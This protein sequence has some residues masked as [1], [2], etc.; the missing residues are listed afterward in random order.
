MLEKISM[1][2]LCP[3]PEPQFLYVEL[4]KDPDRG[5][6]AWHTYDKA[7]NASTPIYQPC[8]Q[9]R[10][11][12]LRLR[13]KKFKD[14]RNLKMDMTFQSGGT[15][16]TVRTGVE[17][18]FA[19]GV[20][21]GLKEVMRQEGDKALESELKILAEAGETS[22]FGNVY[23]VNGYRYRKEWDGDVRLFPVVQEI[24]KELGVP[25]QTMDA[26]NKEFEESEARRSR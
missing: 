4:G 12:G 7:T 2:G 9:G 26:I 19:R 17:T 20:L 16:W 23:S 21:L 13:I 22:V 5:A 24:Q 18:V 11:T 15:T 3:S 25:V 6:Y 10:L 14:D 8:L 1:E